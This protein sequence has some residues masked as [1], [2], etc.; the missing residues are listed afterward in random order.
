MPP[1]PTSPTPSSTLATCWRWEGEPP[2]A[3]VPLPPA[4][5]RAGGD[6]AGAEPVGGAFPRRRGPGAGRVSL[7]RDA[8]PRPRAPGHPPAA[9]DPRA[10]GRGALRH[11][12]LEP[13]HDR[14]HPQVRAGPALG[15]REHPAPA[16]QPLRTGRPGDDHHLDA[17]HVLGRVRQAQR[18]AHD[19]RA[20]PPRAGLLGQDGQGA[21]RA[22]PAGGLRMSQAALGY[23]L[24][25]A[26]AL[27]AVALFMCAYRLIRGPRAQDRVMALDALYMNGLLSIVM[28]GIR[29]GTQ[30]Y[31]E[32]ALVI[33]LT[34]FVST[35]A[36]AKFLMRGEVIE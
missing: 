15:V 5:H 3:R 29:T 12:G 10:H 14:D 33:A 27:L 9:A 32:A 35:S 4:G 31:F 18:R 16:P 26:Q 24:A 8:A 6:V 11:P 2:Q 22:A 30:L 23:C 36:V 34:G 21:L 25:A 28:L 19:P 13:A 1:A 7:A 20:R 17:G